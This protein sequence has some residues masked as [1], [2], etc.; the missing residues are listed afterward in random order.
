M[1]HSFS[2]KRETVGD[3]LSRQGG[4]LARESRSAELLARG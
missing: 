2:M 3:I 1:V 4:S